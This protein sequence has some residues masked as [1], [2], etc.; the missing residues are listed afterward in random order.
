[1]EVLSC[2]TTMLGSS[3]GDVIHQVVIG[4]NGDIVIQMYPSNTMYYTRVNHYQYLI[5]VRVFL[6]YVGGINIKVLFPDFVW[7]VC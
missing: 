6:D 1:M 4:I 5:E 7:R 3:P 2:N